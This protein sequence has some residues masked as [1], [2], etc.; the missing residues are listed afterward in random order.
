MRPQPD[1]SPDA[2][3][4]QRFRAWTIAGAAVASR[5]HTRGIV[6]S[7]QTGVYQLYAWDVPSGER[8]QLTFRSSGTPVG[9]LSPDGRFVYYVEDQGGNELGHVVRVPFEGGD[10]QDVTP[11]LPPYSAAGI[12]M[13]RDARHLGITVATRDGLQTYIIDVGDEG[14]LGERRPIHHTTR[15]M[16]G[17]S[18]SND[19][20]IAVVRVSERSKSTDVDLLAIDTATGA[21]IGELH[22]DDAT[23]AAVRFSRVDGDERL[24][25]STNRSGQI[26][27]L[28]WDPRTGARHDIDLADV[29]GDVTPIDW[30]D[31]G[32]RVLLVRFSAAVQR[33]GVL[34]LA[35][36]A[37]RWLAHPPGMILG[38]HFSGEDEILAMM[39]DSTSPN[40][41]V[42]LDAASGAMKRVVLHGATAPAGTPWRS[43]TFPSSEGARIQAWLATPPGAGPFPTVVHIHGGPDSAI[44]DAFFPAGQAWVDHGFAMLSVNYRGSTTFGR[45]FQMCIRGDLGHRE[46]DDLAAAHA[47]LVSERIAIPEQVFLWGASYGGYLTL[48]G[49]GRLPELWAGGVASV[50]IADWTLLYEDGAETIRRYQAALFGGTPDETPEQHARS[51]PI[52]YAAGVRAPLL[53]IQGANDTRCPP[54][55]MRVYEEKMLELGKR[56]EVVWF[57]AGHG[58]YAIEQNIEHQ[59]RA[60]EFVYGVLGSR[61]ATASP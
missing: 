48:L 40:R 9:S 44:L 39:T 33:L 5:E 50:A 26:R 23:L 12:A 29:D 16:G 18:L 10:A 52:T 19:G 30:S 22:D 11:D 49:L 58:S 46:I 57:D 13:S 36:G 54:R 42:A 20:A 32:A 2:Q 27:P 15:L 38:A 61:A 28:L 37:L 59:E 21:R 51:S 8:R 6:T 53:V 31:D 47:W 14:T 43:V 55:Q 25:C 3:W 45:A 35:A 7:N 17:L 60:L 1:L 41:L 24:L 56:I 34:E 4:K